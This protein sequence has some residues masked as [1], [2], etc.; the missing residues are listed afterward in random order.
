MIYNL[1]IKTTQK[2]QEKIMFSKYCP[3]SNNA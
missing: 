1:I 2:I 3:N